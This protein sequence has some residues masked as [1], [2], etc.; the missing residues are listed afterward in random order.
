MFMRSPNGQVRLL[1]ERRVPFF[2]PNKDGNAE[3]YAPAAASGG[4]SRSAF[5]VRLRSCWGSRSLFG[6]L[7]D[8]FGDD[9]SD[10]IGTARQ[11]EL[12]QRSLIGGNQQGDLFRPE[13][14]IFQ[15]TG[16]RH[17]SR[18]A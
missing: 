11:T 3:S 18:I 17:G 16:E 14:S 4:A 10:R 5:T 2:A 6:E 13:G 1:P 8:L 12:M 15:E 7:Y 9:L